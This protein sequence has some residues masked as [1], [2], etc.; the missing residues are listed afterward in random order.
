[1]AITRSQMKKQITNSLQKRK[2]AK[3][4]KNKKKVI[5]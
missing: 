5:T 3:T 4:R 2:F 1:M